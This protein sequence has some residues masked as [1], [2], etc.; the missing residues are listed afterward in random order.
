MEGLKPSHLELFSITMRLLKNF[1]GLFCKS[2]TNNLVEIG[3]INTLV[4]QHEQSLFVLLLILFVSNTLSFL[5]HLVLGGLPS[6]FSSHHESQTMSLFECT[7]YLNSCH[8]ELA[9]VREGFHLNPSLLFLKDTTIHSLIFQVQERMSSNYQFV[10]TCWTRTLTKGIIV[11]RVLQRKVKAYWNHT[12][13][14]ELHKNNTIYRLFNS[15]KQSNYH[16]N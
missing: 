6:W 14:Y 3:H 16:I 9:T 13:T 5:A 1:P 4:V 10:R 15:F 7:I 12:H 8:Q 2:S 11:K